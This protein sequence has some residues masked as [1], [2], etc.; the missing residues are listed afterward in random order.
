MLSAIEQSLLTDFMFFISMLSKKMYLEDK[1]M[2]GA[3]RNLLIIF[4]ALLG[5]SKHSNNTY[6]ADLDQSDERCRRTSLS[7]C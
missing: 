1:W 2:E 7:S 4:P 5:S 3:V 6:T